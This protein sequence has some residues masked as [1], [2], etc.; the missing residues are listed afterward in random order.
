MSYQEQSSLI[1]CSIIVPLLV[2]LSHDLVLFSSSLELLAWVFVYLS[3]SILW[4]QGL[5]FVFWGITLHLGQ[6]LAIV[7]AQKI[8][9]KQMNKGMN[10][11]VTPGLSGKATEES[12]WWRSL[13]WGWHGP[14]S[15]KQAAE[16]WL[17]P[18]RAS[19]VSPPSW[20]LITVLPV[21]SD[22]EHL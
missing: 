21:L 16:Q 9:V 3:P 10:E 19:P 6:N 12:R 15:T 11:W 8:F 1:N 14:H 7:D 17:I 13:P 5:Y 22:F 18:S 2:I 20:M 4:R